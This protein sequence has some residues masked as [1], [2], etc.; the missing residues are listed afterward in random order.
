MQTDVLS[1]L[2]NCLDA[3]SNAYQ[4]NLIPYDRAFEICNIITTRMEEDLN[5]GVKNDTEEDFSD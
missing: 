3:V 5:F 1:D 4:S 2:A